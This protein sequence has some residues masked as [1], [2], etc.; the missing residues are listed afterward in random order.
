ML[1]FILFY[2]SF[3]IIIIINIIYYQLS[4]QIHFMPLSLW[5]PFFDC[6]PLPLALPLLTPPS[7]SLFF[8]FSFLSTL[9]T[10]YFTFLIHLHIRII[11]MN[12][13][14]VLS[15]LSVCRTP[16]S[17]LSPSLSSS[18]FS[19]LFFNFFIPFLHLP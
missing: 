19:S 15:F 5:R 7:F 17:H 12:E 9:P 13:V 6:A 3:F 2:G 10:F 4:M 18:P 14:G 16:L 11:Y 8:L 1:S